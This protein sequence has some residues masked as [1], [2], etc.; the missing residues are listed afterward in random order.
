MSRRLVGTLVILVGALWLVGV[1]IAAM[2]IRHEIDEVFDS[3]LQ[4]TAQR[5]LPLALDDLDSHDDEE[6]P[7][8]ELADPFPMEEHEE[9]LLYQVRDARGR[10]LLRSH[11]APVIAFPVPL[12]R[13]YFEDN[14]R[15]YFTEESANGQLFIQVAEVAEERQ[16]AVAALW[17]GLIAPLLGLLPISAIAVDWMVRRATQPITKVQSQIAKRGGEN[18]DPIDPYGLPLEL[19]PII[20]DMNRLLQRLEAALDA[21]R[22]FAA[23]SA[24]ELRNPIAAARAQA[25]IVAEVLRD[26]PDEVRARQ[27]VDTLGRLSKQIEKMLQLARAEAGL[28]YARPETDLVQVAR[29]LVNDYSQRPKL[30]DRLRFDAGDEDSVIVGIDPDAL[31][32]ALQNLIDNALAHGAPDTPIMIAVGPGAIVSVVNE[33]PAVSASELPALTKPF[34]R[35]DARRA[36]GAG[37]GLSIVKQLMRQADAR[38]ELFSPARGKDSG[39]EAILIFPRVHARLDL[40]G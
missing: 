31:G 32:I 20:Q 10:V 5:L 4:E 18:L 27:L 36:P 12:S 19:M 2:S 33:G 1:G 23:N 7:E 6:A 13:G 21:E 40:K 9:Y 35:G 29:L 34:E 15:R 38:L 39:F 11:D 14:G 24:H 25:E 3:A 26:T 30:V 8:R 37:L 17:M 16:E 28:G 22:S